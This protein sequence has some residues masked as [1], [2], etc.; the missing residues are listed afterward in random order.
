[1]AFD[2]QA[3]ISGRQDGRHKWQR[4]TLSDH[5]GLQWQGAHHQPHIQM[6]QCMVHLQVAVYME[7]AVCLG[8]V[9]KS[10]ECVCWK[11]GGDKMS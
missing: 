8:C 1:M 7:I 2:Q 11:V 3:A 4:Y 6:N 5:P 9:Q 10:N